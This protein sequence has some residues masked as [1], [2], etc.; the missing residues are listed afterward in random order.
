LIGHYEDIDRLEALVNW[1]ETEYPSPPFPSHR[2]ERHRIEPIAPGV[3]ISEAQFVE[4][5]DTC[6][7]LNDTEGAAHKLIGADGPGLTVG[8]GRGY[9]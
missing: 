3:V 8:D 4:L 1:F 6:R 7:H 5:I 2:I 9:L